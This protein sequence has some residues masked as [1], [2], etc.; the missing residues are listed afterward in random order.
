MP[1]PATA[2]K[3]TRRYRGNIATLFALFVAVFA[4]IL[5]T[6]ERIVIRGDADAVGLCDRDL[7]DSFAHSE[8]RKRRSLES[9]LR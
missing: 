9:S 8:A 2:A 1:I 3:M 4:L 5:R 7:G 6:T